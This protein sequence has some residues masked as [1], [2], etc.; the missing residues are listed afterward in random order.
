MECGMPGAKIPKIAH[1]HIVDE[2]AA[3]RIDRRDVG[4]AAQHS[5]PLGGLVPMQLAHAAGIQ[6]HVDAGD[7][8]GDRQ[9]PLGH[10]TRPAAV[11]SRT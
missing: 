7:G 1:A 10:L 5:G 8:R 6:A 9:L 11:A 2:V 4:A 3:L